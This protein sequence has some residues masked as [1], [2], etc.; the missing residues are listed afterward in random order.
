MDFEL[1]RQAEYSTNVGKMQRRGLFGLVAGA[2]ACI[3]PQRGQ[4][5]SLQ[6]EP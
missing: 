3:G 5:P 1:I 6:I 4:A 2:D